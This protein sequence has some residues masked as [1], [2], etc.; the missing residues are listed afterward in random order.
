MQVQLQPEFDKV[1][2]PLGSHALEFFL[3][4]SLYHAR[5]ITVA[6]AAHM[7]GLDFDAFKNRF[8]EHFSA[9]ATATELFFSASPMR[10]AWAATAAIKSLRACGA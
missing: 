8:S 7:A 9:G 6:S 5:K 10:W 1:L 4:A 3:A 2:Q